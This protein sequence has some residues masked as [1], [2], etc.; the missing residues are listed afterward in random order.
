MQRLEFHKVCNEAWMYSV[1]SSLRGILD[2]REI[3]RSM[4]LVL[5][6]TLDRREKVRASS[7]SSSLRDCF[8]FGRKNPR[9][10]SYTW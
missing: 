6:R 2:I 8:Q 9:Q 7:S 3:E 4:H 5:V 10:D 1:E